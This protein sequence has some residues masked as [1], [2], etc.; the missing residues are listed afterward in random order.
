MSHARSKKRADASRTPTRGARRIANFD[1]VPKPGGN[2][3]PIPILAPDPV[4]ADLQR[5]RQIPEGHTNPANPI[6]IKEG[7]TQRAQGEA[8]FDRYPAWYIDHVMAAFEATSDIGRQ[9]NFLR[10]LVADPVGATQP[11]FTDRVC[12]RRNEAYDSDEED[13]TP[14]RKTQY[15]LDL[16]AYQLRIYKHMRASLTLFMDE[17]AKNKFE[18][19]ISSQEVDLTPYQRSQRMERHERIPWKRI[20]NFVLDHIC[21][22]TLGSFHFKPLLRLKRK[23][24]QLF[25][26]W[27]HTVRKIAEKVR[28][29]GR[30]WEKIIDR[31]AMHVLKDWTSDREITALN[32]YLVKKKLQDEHPSITHMANNLSVNEFI[33]IFRDIDPK[34]L[35]SKFTQSMEKTAIKATMLTYDE[36]KK[37]LEELTAK[38]ETLKRDKHNIH[39]DLIR[40]KEKTTKRKRENDATPSKSQKE[41]ANSPKN[42]SPS[43]DY[44]PGPDEYPNV[45][46]NKKY[47]KAKRGCCQRCH[48]V[49]LK[50]RKH[51]TRCDPKFREQAVLRLKKK[52][53]RKQANRD[54]N[55]R[56]HPL[57]SYPADACEH[58]VR[59][60]V[61]PKY[62]T[63]HSP[64]ACYR[65][66][67]GIL[68]QKKIVGKAARLKE[69]LRLI[70]QKMQRNKEEHGSERTATSRVTIAIAPSE[71]PKAELKDTSTKQRS[72]IR[73]TPAAATSKP[74]RE[75][76][77]E[78]D[79]I[80]WSA[81]QKHVR[82]HRYIR[83][84]TAVN[85]PLTDR[86]LDSIINDPEKVHDERTRQ[87]TRVNFESLA[88]EELLIQHRKHK[89]TPHP[90]SFS[91]AG[92]GNQDYLDEYNRCGFAQQEEIAHY[93]RVHNDKPPPFIKTFNT[94]AEYLKKRFLYTTNGEIVRMFDAIH[95]RW[96]RNRGAKGEVYARLTHV[97]QCN[98][99]KGFTY[100]HG[101]DH[102]P[103]ALAFP[104]LTNLSTDQMD[105]V[106]SRFQQFLQGHTHWYR[107]E[108][109]IRTYLNKLWKHREE[110]RKAK[111]VR[112]QRQQRQAKIR[113]RNI[114]I[115]AQQAERKKKLD[116]ERE[117]RK[118][119]AEIV[120]SRKRAERIEQMK[121]E[122]EALKAEKAK[123]ES[124]RN[125]AQHRIE[126]LESTRQYE[127]AKHK[128]LLRERDLRERLTKRKRSQTQP[129]NKPSE[130][131]PQEKQSR[132]ESSECVDL[133][134]RLQEER[135]Q[136]RRQ[137]RIETIE[138]TQTMLNIAQEA[139]AAGEH[140]AID[141]DDLRSSPSMSTSPEPDNTDDDGTEPPTKERNP[142]RKRRMSNMT[143]ERTHSRRE[144]A[145]RGASLKRTRKHHKKRHSARM[146]TGDTSSD[147]DSEVDGKASDCDQNN[148]HIQDLFRTSS[149]EDDEPHV[150]LTETVRGD[151]HSSSIMSARS[152][153]ICPQTVAE[154]RF[155]KQHPKMKKNEAYYDLFTDILG[156]PTETWCP[157]TTK[158]IPIA[159]TYVS[160]NKQNSDP[161]YLLPSEKP[162]CRLLQAY[163]NYR[164]RYGNIK[165]GRIQLDT[166]SNVNY[167][168]REVGLPRPHRHG[169]ATKVKGISDKTIRLGK[170]R[171]FTLMKNDEPVVVDCN[172]APN[173]LLKG[174][175]VA[176]LGLDAITMLGI[177]INHAVEHDRHVDVRFKIATHELCNAAKRQA[178]DRYPKRKQLERYIH[179]TCC[180]S[181]RVCAEYIKHHPNDYKQEAIQP[182]SMDIASSMPMEYRNRILSFLMKYSDVFAQSTNTLPCPLKDVP[183]HIF[184]L[185]EDATPV[186]SGRPKFGK[187]QAK[188]IN[189]WVAWA[190]EVGLIE[191]ATTTSWSSRLILA[192]KYNHD[193]PKS[194]LPDGIRV[195]WAGVEVNDRIQ[196][197]VPTYPDAWEQ[198]YKVANLK[199]K[200][201]A[202]GLKQYWSIDLDKKSREITAFWTP[203]GLFQFTRLVMGTKNAA[204]VA[205]NAY[206]HALNTQLD[207][208][209]YDHIA[210]F[211][212]DFLGGGNTYES[213]LKHFEAFLKMCRASGITL[214]PKKI[215]IGYEQEQF[216]GLSVNNG[217]IEP[218][219]RN[220]DPV[221]RV[222][223]PKS[224][225][226]LRSIMGIFNQF[227]SFIKDYGRQKGPAAT[228]NS[229]MSPK[230]PF[231][232]TKEHEKALD[233]LKKQ[234]L[235][236]V[237]LYAP[238]NNHQLILETDGSIDG[239]GAVLYQIIKGEKRI[240]KMWSKQWKTEA[241]QKKP[242]YHRE[243]KAWMNGLT[244]T[245]PYAL[246]NK[247]PVKCYTDHT[248][249]TWIKHTSGKGPVSQFIVDTL[250]IIDYE[251]NYIK[252]KDNVTADAL[253]RFPLL[254]PSQLHQH[255][256]VKAVNI[257][258]SALITSD[259]DVSRLW[260]YTG[261]DTQH[262]ISDV[263]D[264][265]HEYSKGKPPPKR[266]PHCFMDPLSSSKIG[267][268]R[269]TM[270]IWAP[271]ADKITH[272]C[273]TAFEKNVPFACL[274]PNDLV[275]RIATD[276][277]G[278]T[279]ETIHRRIEKAFKIVLL[280]PGLTWI[281][282]GLNFD[283]SWTIRTVYA[284]EKDRPSGNVHGTGRVTE[285]FELQELVKILK[286]SNLTP[287]LPQFSTRDKW[288]EEQRKHRTK[289]IYEN[290][291]GLHTAQ[292]GLLVYQEEPGSPLRT[293]VP[294]SIAIPLVEWQHKNLCH[295]G[296]QKVLS[297]LKARFYWKGMRR[298]CEYVNEQCALCNLLKARMK[299]AHKHFRPKIHCRP[300][301]AYG[302]DYYAVQQN[303]QGYNNILGIID[304]A[305]GHLVLSAVKKRSGANTAHVVFYEIVVRKGVPQLFHSDAAKELIGKAMTA[306]STI[307]GFKLS[308]TLAH[309]PKGNA[310]IERVWAYVGNCLQSLTPQQ[311]S[312]FH[313]YLPII[314][315]VWNTIPDSDT[316][317]TPFE[318]EHGMKC[319]S[320]AESILEDPP[321]EGLP[322]TADD[323]RTIAT[324]V[325]AFN[326]VIANVK[327]VEKAQAANRLN[328]NGTSK[329]TYEL[330]DQVAFY[331]PPDQNTVKKM[332]K[333]R[334]HILQYCGPAEIVE[335]L[336]P[337]RTSFKLRY[338][339]K[340][341]YRNVMHLSRYK[342]HEEVPAELQIVVDNTVSVGSYVAVLDD[343]EDR[344]Y[345]MA[346]VIDVNDRETTLHYLGTKSR[347]LRSAVWFKLYRHP[348]TN[349]V[350]FNQPENLVRN[351]TRYTGSID[352][353]SPEESLII[354]ANIGFTDM[355]RINTASRRILS[356]KNVSH[357]VMTQTWDP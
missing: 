148:T 266:K 97:A 262:L 302:A 339:G 71:E 113:Q 93:Q 158:K 344:H 189:D 353:K 34:E 250:S 135:R 350:T 94:F 210:N 57:G 127:N 197:T 199:Y 140:Y 260:F 163:I 187:A 20:K 104:N 152:T 311:Y 222:T 256:T 307:L 10:H 203:Q 119:H 19:W 83:N 18:T 231:V 73:I 292:D 314:A 118:R 346:Q 290:L 37:A 278:K 100:P 194:A 21:S 338:K 144:L 121:A 241:W 109:H 191:R 72:K 282:H 332:G 174:D 190:L 89:R 284:G 62:S 246:Q 243:A 150:D 196:K 171:A 4:D 319:A 254:G 170:P 56:Q 111:F 41:K 201:S 192:P 206:T 281:I 255:G 265:R 297:T 283:E 323:L 340:S 1:I 219:S 141:P 103:F 3:A 217:K 329:I 80:R 286:D 9:E 161:K 51:K 220:L 251:M 227:S 114:E 101:L 221:K 324:S 303:K 50:N 288:I 232:F 108:K 5:H 309:N 310:K 87:Q 268:I 215:R 81:F 60:D 66:P 204:T 31:E 63:G 223:T 315:H 86:E 13:S 67:G 184:K 245:I 123:A 146:S 308:N 99:W 79:D 213:L 156:I 236:G 291:P 267:T 24:H 180:L 154:Q 242:T 105:Q 295:A 280:T 90:L 226:E 263:Y 258:L 136:S 305:D 39:A 92:N 36:H 333:K 153:Y 124:E 195:A 129:K 139:L 69:V 351:W 322:A 348:G 44:E 331:L 6:Q 274:V 313:L 312:H 35:P 253:S 11:P 357:H 138:H 240:I 177:D 178:I 355:M 125:K 91:V 179:A 249:L 300:R 167:V 230:T 16:E 27:A 202:D 74:D 321:R 117:E 188:I 42:T 25:L 354:S 356:R 343:D 193:T 155:V 47:G 273:R 95:A 98:G 151:A 26:P 23:D 166:Y 181:E 347:T 15:M 40:L 235:D 130:T 277:R 352:T 162:G 293:I 257:L 318:A 298:V 301:T 325:T 173:N 165:R 2:S 61:P 205:Q 337:N 294:D 247:F 225:S 43:K 168:T 65:R 128:A 28:D 330:G 239:W 299:L 304:L 68:D 75:K 134:K 46:I 55:N 233:A 45:S 159:R 264:W 84:M 234:I 218:A 149:D 270:G 33:R 335:I 12:W 160:V 120:T 126:Q 88:G 198:L 52:K 48:N 147:S 209:S 271:P 77:Y 182:E 336:S 70:K 164:D 252:G 133:S 107:D 185:R 32:A 259:V 327:A 76:H 29:H 54:D 58:C 214:N 342:S 326:E 183:P 53:Q 143:H 244:L 102:P 216:Y 237:H 200:F 110:T 64:D 49:G 211:A 341:Y 275:H 106:D 306:L 276:N 82:P 116:K 157:V 137:R 316:G 59:E 112:E 207:R 285:E 349:Q 38:Y 320:V 345:H 14:H 17:P 78:P 30:G 186:R 8:F 248:P 212:D 238:D 142:Q 289:L 228:L 229:L 172:T 269:Y 287:P 208:D 224:R 22:V 115:A 7:V 334:K 176:L 122:M 317:I 261:K 279:C 145:L 131:Q 132:S 296:P 169:E 328:R 85:A 272:Q 96:E 175:C